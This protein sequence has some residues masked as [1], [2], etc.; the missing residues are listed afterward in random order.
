LLTDWAK[1]TD[2][3]IFY[4]RKREMSHQVQLLYVVLIE[5]PRE[6]GE[7]SAQ[8]GRKPMLVC[9]QLGH[10]MVPRDLAELIT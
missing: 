3:I 1:R 6:K 2:T 9:E 7:F 5:S 8:R 10:G 4:E